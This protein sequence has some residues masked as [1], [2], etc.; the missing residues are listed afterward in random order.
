MQP[1]MSLYTGEVT[2]RVDPK[3]H[4]YSFKYIIGYGHATD[5][6]KKP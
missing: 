5:E 3:L 2:R 6:K 1:A 4:F